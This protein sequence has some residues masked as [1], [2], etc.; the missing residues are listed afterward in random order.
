[1]VCGGGKICWEKQLLTHVEAGW[2]GLFFWL[3]TAA[4]D[5]WA[6]RVVRGCQADPRTIWGASAKV[7]MLVSTDTTVFSSGKTVKT[8]SNQRMVSMLP[9]LRMKRCRRF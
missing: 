3:P 9:V 8:S 7:G 4:S 2:P 5:A 1:M 6:R